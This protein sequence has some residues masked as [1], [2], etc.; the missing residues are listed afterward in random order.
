M[1]AN[2]SH[3]AS[4]LIQSAS[5][6]LHRPHWASLPCLSLA[7]SSLLP[8][9]H[10]YSK[11]N[12]SQEPLSSYLDHFE[13]YLSIVEL[14]FFRFSPSFMLLKR[15]NI[16]YA[17]VRRLVP[18]KPSTHHLLSQVFGCKIPNHSFLSD[19]FNTEAGGAF[20]TFVPRTED[21][22]GNII[23]FQVVRVRRARHINDGG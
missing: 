8:A 3:R 16:G 7:P 9:P 5:S 22:I 6:H 20:E 18:F 17:F 12:R 11:A 21:I 15:V 1:N 14:L 2:L 4:S 19:A 23:L 13:I 10:S